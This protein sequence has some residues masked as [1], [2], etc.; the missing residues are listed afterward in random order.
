MESE[1]IKNEFMRQVRSEYAVDNAKRLIDT[2][3]KNCFD[4]CVPKPG[5]SL[6]S[7]EHTC[8]TACM[9][10]YLQSWNHVNSTYVGRLQRG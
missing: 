6:S 7:G 1:T 3:N 9:E 8:F 10:K 2:L 4:R 5:T